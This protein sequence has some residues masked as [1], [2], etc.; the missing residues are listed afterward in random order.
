VVFGLLCNPTSPVASLLG[1]VSHIYSG[2]ECFMISSLAGS[3][4]VDSIL[5]VDR[6]LP[7]LTCS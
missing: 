6:Q 5:F 2:F 7:R 3:Y 4:I 1:C